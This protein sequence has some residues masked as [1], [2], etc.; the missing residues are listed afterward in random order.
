[1][2]FDDFT[3]HAPAELQIGFYKTVQQVASDLGVGSTGYRLI[4]NHGGDGGQEVPHYHVHLLGGEKVG[5]LV[6]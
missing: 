2:S 4:S 5:K 6:I 1:V 3:W